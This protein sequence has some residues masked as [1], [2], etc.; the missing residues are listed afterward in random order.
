MNRRTETQISQNRY[1]RKEKG[2]ELHEKS[3]SS[4]GYG[5]PSK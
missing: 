5:V 2:K 3:E 4:M 1:A